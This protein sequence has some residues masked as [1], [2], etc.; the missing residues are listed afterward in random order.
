MEHTEPGYWAVLPAQIRYAGIPAGAKIL[1]AE[2]SS[3]TDATGY[4]WA[5][6]QYFC[7]LY[8]ISEATLQRYLRAL[9]TGGWISIQDGDG[10]A[11]RRKIFAG[12]NPLA[13]NPLKNDGV[14]DNPIKND[15]VTPSEMT[16]SLN[17][18]NKK[19]NNKPPISPKRAEAP[20]PAE[21][22]ERVEKYA[23][24]D[25]QLQ[26]ALLG[27]ADNRRAIRKP[28]KTQR[29]LTLLLSRLNELSKG[30]R[31]DKLALIEKATMNNW[32]SF[33]PLRE[34]ELPAPEAARTVERPEVE[35]W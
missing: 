14:P 19:E 28:V 15:G 34:D 4:C 6:N 12:I 18:I 33:Y 25:L 30:R 7:N 22:M 20:M 32:L 11:G 29:T 13:A 3:L 8:A 10:G 5:S 23:G 16:G 24:G 2:I 9:K 26:E 27:F 31:Q 21:L 1:Y 17:S 35:R